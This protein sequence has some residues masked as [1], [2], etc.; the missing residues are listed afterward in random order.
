MP[1]TVAF[2]EKEEELILKYKKTDMNLSKI[3]TL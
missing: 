3:I 1:K 2:K